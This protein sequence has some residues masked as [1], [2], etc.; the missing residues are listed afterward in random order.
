MYS[1]FFTRSGQKMSTASKKKSV[2]SSTA[3]RFGFLSENRYFP[4]AHYF[5]WIIL[6]EKNRQFRSKIETNDSFSDIFRS[7]KT[8]LSKRQRNN[9]FSKGEDCQLFF[10]QFIVGDKNSSEK[11]KNPIVGISSTRIDD[12]IVLHW[13]LYLSG[14]MSRVA[15]RLSRL[16]RSSKSL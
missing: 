3:D 4:A 14:R 11:E 2:A 6:T 8:I 5:R 1:Y 16:T 13:R 10:L 9:F 12:W 15:R 7:P